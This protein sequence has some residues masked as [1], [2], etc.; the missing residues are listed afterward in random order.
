V[1]IPQ[2]AFNFFGFE[3][4]N[5]GKLIPLLEKKAKEVAFSKEN[6]TVKVGKNDGEVYRIIREPLC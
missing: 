5:T 1:H 4:T 3:N 6:L 2:H